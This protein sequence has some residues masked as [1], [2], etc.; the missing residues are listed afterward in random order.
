MHHL[1]QIGEI[2]YNVEFDEHICNFWSSYLTV[3][4]KKHEKVHPLLVEHNRKL[5]A[6][7]MSQ[8][9]EVRNPEQ[10]SKYNMWQKRYAKDRERGAELKSA[11]ALLQKDKR[12]KKLRK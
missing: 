7:N 8:K 12:R 1:F 10:V 3:L 11:K 5:K 9:E 4:N 2:I 6:K